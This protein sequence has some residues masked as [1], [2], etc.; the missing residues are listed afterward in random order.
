MTRNIH[1]AQFEGYVG[2]WRPGLGE[3]HRAFSDAHRAFGSVPTGDNWSATMPLTHARRRLEGVDRPVIPVDNDRVTDALRQ[4]VR[5]T[6]HPESVDPRLLMATQTGVTNRGMKY[7]MNPENDYER[8]GATF[9][10]RG[11][12]GNR[13]PVIYQNDDIGARFLLSGHHR[14]TAAILRGT[15]L[16]AVVVHGDSGSWGRNVGRQWHQLWAGS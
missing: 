11:N 6:L 9:A 2:D 13:H 5:G 10:D 7:Y 3:G 14:A 8:H 4:V 15:P 12:I 16:H 1:P